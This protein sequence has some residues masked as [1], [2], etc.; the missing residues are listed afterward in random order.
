[1]WNEI[2][3]EKT[4]FVLPFNA[5]SIQ[6]IGQISRNDPSETPFF[7]YFPRFPS[8]TTLDSVWNW[9]CLWLFCCYLVLLGFAWIP[10]PG[11]YLVSA[12]RDIKR[13]YR[14][15]PSFYWLGYHR[16]TTCTWH[17]DLTRFYWVFRALEYN[18]YL[19]L[20]SFQIYL[21]SELETGTVLSLPSFF[22]DQPM[23]RF[24]LFSL[25]K[26]SNMAP[27]SEDETLNNSLINC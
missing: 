2:S 25:H 4:R 5:I 24:R 7:H 1:M 17:G 11:F 16:D 15:L 6:F 21:Q 13:W 9:C 12:S 14:V 18:S 20:P 8:G 23:L 10:M 26:I 22:H 19:N 27:V 3:L